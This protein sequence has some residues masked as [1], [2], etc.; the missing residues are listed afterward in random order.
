MF[1][2]LKEGRI[3]TL[4]KKRPVYRQRW[5]GAILHNHI[6]GSKW[7]PLNINVSY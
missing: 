7:T 1:L 5:T 3:L 4:Q 2:F 6:G